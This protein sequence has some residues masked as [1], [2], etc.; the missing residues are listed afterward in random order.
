LRLLRA[1]LSGFL[2]FLPAGLIAALD[3]PPMSGTAAAPG[4]VIAFHRAVV[5]VDDDIFTMRSDGSNLRPLTSDSNQMDVCPAL[6]FDGRQ[7]AFGS[8]REGIEQI[9][10]M[11]SDG[12]NPRRIT[13]STTPNRMPAWS[14]DGKRIAF[15]RE[16]D[17]HY[18][19]F[20]TNADG[21]GERRLTYTSAEES[22]AWWSPDGKKIV[23]GSGRSGNAD[24]Y[25]MN[26][27]GS[28]QTRLT[29][30]PTGEYFP[31][32]SPDGSRIAYTAVLNPQDPMLLPRDLFVMNADG[33]GI[34]RLTTGPYLGQEPPGMVP[35]VFAP[36][37]VSIPEAA[38]WGTAF[39]PDGWQFYF[40]R[41]SAETAGGDIYYTKATNGVWTNPA[42]APFWTDHQD[43]EPFVTHDGKTLFFS[44]DRPYDGRVEGRIWGV[45][46]KKSG[47]SSAGYAKGSVNAGFSM[48]LTISKKGT[49]VY[50][51]IGPGGSSDIYRATYA[52]GSFSDST[53]IGP[54]VSTEAHEAHP[55]VA[56]DDSFI[57]F[58]A[59]RTGSYGMSD[60]YIAFRTGND[61]WGDP[62]N[63]GPTINSSDY[64]AFGYVSPD[65]KYFFFGK[66]GDIYWADAKVL[67]RLKPTDMACAAVTMKPATASRGAAVVLGVK[68]V[69]RSGVYSMSTNVQFYLDRGKVVGKKSISLGTVDVDSIRPHSSVLLKLES[70]IPEDMAPGEYYL[71]ASI[72][73][74]DWNCDP[75]RKNNAACRAQRVVIN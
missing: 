73:A 57:V 13:Q 1:T 34:R 46:I 71:L 24:I 41:S 75:N 17:G 74:D 25:V 44:S 49:A 63:L 38:D 15:E 51:G 64:D 6:T 61:S 55:F 19:I 42:R 32:W 21:T 48:Y 54:P 5:G 36:G 72:D 4:E 28:R 2:S 52:N 29:S 68:V 20:T 26:P 66:Y 16:I 22:H 45:T 37:I 35:E 14:P 59:E 56:S 53:R 10:V 31:A 30:T 40:T 11:N 8:A 69:N 70:S 18:Q 43:M 62:I 7:I 67:K 47:W 58:D 60:L 39:T 12:S 33:T 9:Y 50:T 23:F 3:P 65:R 27:D